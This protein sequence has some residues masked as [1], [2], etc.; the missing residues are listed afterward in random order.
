MLKKLILGVASSF[1]L[2]GTASAASIF[3]SGT[4]DAGAMA[5]SQPASF[6]AIFGSVGG[7]D[8]GTINNVTGTRIFTTDAAAD[9]LT[10]VVNSFLTGSANDFIAIG[11]ADNGFGTPTGLNIIQTGIGTGPTTITIDAATVSAAIAAGG[12]GFFDIIVADD[13]NV[14]FFELAT[15]GAGPVIP[16]PAALPLMAS[17]LIGGVIARRRRNK[18]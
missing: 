9:T 8:V 1:M 16:V 13:T 17:A 6:N 18:A 15:V 11:N 14:D 5:L 3:S 12:G 10:I 4:D 2:M 7:T